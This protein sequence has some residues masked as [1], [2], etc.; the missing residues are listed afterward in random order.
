MFYVMT[1][2]FVIQP[3][4]DRD[5]PSWL[6]LQIREFDPRFDTSKARGN[7]L[8]MSN[9]VADG[10]WTLGFPNSKACETA[11]LLILEE[12]GKQRSFVESMLAPLLQDDFLG[13]LSDNQEE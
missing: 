4:I 9:H 11:R 6:H 5:H 10:R 2:L 7:H 3:K 12:T 13:N 8:K 1:L